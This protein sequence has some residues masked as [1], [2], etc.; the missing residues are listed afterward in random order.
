MPAKIPLRKRILPA[1][2]RRL[3]PLSIQIDPFLVVRESRESTNFEPHH[4]SYEFGFLT[5]ADLDELIR[6]EP[7]N[8]KCELLDWFRQGKLCFGVKD[9]NRLIAKMWCDLD[10][11][12]YPPNFRHLSPNEAYL[13]AAY[14]DPDCRG[15]DIAPKMRTACYSSLQNIGRSSFLSYTDY[16]N[17]SARRFKSK[18]GAR[19]EALR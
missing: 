6:L 19:D 7:R 18:L 12:N 10:T 13:F 2:L 5:E 14:A 11:F 15:Q 9:D 8:N 4:S 3:K 1:I 16:F 17:A